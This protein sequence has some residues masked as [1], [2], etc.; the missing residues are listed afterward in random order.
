MRIRLLVLAVISTCLAPFLLGQIFG[1]IKERDVALQ[2]VEHGLNTSI[3]RVQDLFVEIQADTESTSSIIA[4]N[5]TFQYA[6][7]EYCHDRLAAIKDKY[8]RI[9]HISILTPEGTV[10]CSSI[11]GVEGIS[12]RNSSAFSA[13]LHNSNIYWGDVQKSVISKS[14]VIPSVM[15]VRK[16]GNIDYL[17]VSSLNIFALKRTTFQM[18]DVP[19]DK[20]ALIDGNGKIVDSVSFTNQ[21]VEIS[22]DIVKQALTIDLGLITRPDLTHSTSY[23]G[24]VKFPMNS[25]RVVFSAPV[26]EVYER[27]H[28]KMV[29][30]IATAT[31]EALILAF[32]AMVA[33]ELLFL[34]A[35]RKI[36]TLAAAIT[37]GA[38]GQRI[39]VKSPFADF[40]VLASAL[41]LMV[42]KLEDASR[43]DS[44]TGLANRRALDS[45]LALGDQ[46][47]LNGKQSFAIA[48]LDI[49]NFKLFN[50][51]FGHAAGDAALQKV[52][53]ALTSFTKR[54][55][56]L[57]ARYGGEEFT[58]VL[59]ES[60]EKV[61][62]MHLDAVRRAVEDL[63]IAHPDSPY[64][65]ITLSIGYAMASPGLTMHKMIERADVALYR[66][67][68]NGR[69]AISG[70]G[71]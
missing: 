3:R 34:R 60:D 68:A 71:D 61:L 65:H 55:G 33:V 36:S 43:L 41:N 59:N 64:G 42:E 54:N 8:E 18:F 53:Q 7:P 27:A 9:E 1:A 38:E 66:S 14:V 26:L 37:T 69:N 24:V 25:A 19:L 12:A 5:N 46:L 35:F 40:T 4:A 2:Y 28:H 31:L 45:H 20:A 23:I 48:M 32:I 56:E 6:S 30:A 10:F 29:V 67:K 22:D 57:A 63:A 44:L 52:G 50:D 70:A 39:T 16:N 17:I 62:L 47:I 13:S 58:L 15:A 21:N 49:D 51:R 11:N